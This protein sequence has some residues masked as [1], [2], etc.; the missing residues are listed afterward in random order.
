L[1]ALRCRTGRPRRQRPTARA[2]NKPLQTWWAARVCGNPW[3]PARA[4]GA[5]TGAKPSVCQPAGVGCG[6][7]LPV[8]WVQTFPLRQP[9]AWWFRW[10]WRGGGVV[11]RGKGV[12]GHPWRTQTSPMVHKSNPPHRGFPV[13]RVACR[14]LVG[15]PL[16]EGNRRADIGTGGAFR[17]HRGDG[18]AGPA[19]PR[20]QPHSADGGVDLCGGGFRHRVLA[21]AGCESD[22]LYSTFSYAPSIFVTEVPLHGV[23]VA[24]KAHKPKSPPTG[25]R[26]GLLPPSGAAC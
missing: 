8:C 12:L 9:S 15:M 7:C 5:P 22:A 23:S 6:P 10:L 14:V 19:E 26:V 1:A 13:T 3:S 24:L 17:G 20:G 21:G 4:H 18:A 16:R 25:Q 2:E 11:G